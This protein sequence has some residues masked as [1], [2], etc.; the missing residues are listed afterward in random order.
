[1]HFRLTTGIKIKRVCTA[2]SVGAWNW[3]CQERQSS[4]LRDVTLPLLGQHVSILATHTKR[5]VESSWIGL[6]VVCLVCC[7]AQLVTR[8]ANT[9]ACIGCLCV[10]G[11]TI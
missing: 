10:N 7:Q 4:V 2:C 9:S 6:G 3:Q 5:T 11:L 1:M 8:I